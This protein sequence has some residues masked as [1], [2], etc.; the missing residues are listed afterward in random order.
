MRVRPFNIDAIKIAYSDQE[1]YVG[2]CKV[3]DIF[4]IS[5]VSR[6]DEDPESGFQRMLGD[7]RAKQISEYIKSGNLIPGAL[8]LSAQEGVIR[9][10]DKAKKKLTINPSKGALLVIDGQHRLYGAH[11]SGVDVYFPIC[12]FSNL[13]KEQEVQFFIDVN[14]FQRGVPKALRLELTKFTAEP[15]S[16]DELLNEIFG[17][18]DENPESPLFGK[19]ARTRSVTGKI[20]HVAFRNG[21]KLVLENPIFTAF[22]IEQKKRVVLNYLDAVDRVLLENFDGEPKL[23]NAAFFSGGN[24]GF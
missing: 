18:L 5:K 20:S 3:N 17:E 11:R 4:D 16:D 15:G 13:S 6:A 14:G 12:I 7:N 19:M 9:S 1:Y 24:G 8:I 23:T 10:Y 2:V 22:R 21:F